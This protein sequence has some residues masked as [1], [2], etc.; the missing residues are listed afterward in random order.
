MSKIRELKK[1]K[2]IIKRNRDQRNV[3]SKWEKKVAKLP[4]NFKKK[5]VFRWDGSFVRNKM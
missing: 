4:M 3:V 2:C 5:K 1:K